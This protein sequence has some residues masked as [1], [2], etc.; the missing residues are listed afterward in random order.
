MLENAIKHA[1]ANESRHLAALQDFIRIPSI[2]T[3]PDH[4]PD[5]Q[6]AASW[7]AE[8]IQS[9]GAPTVE[10]FAEPASHP[11]VYAD[12]PS[13]DPLA[14]TIL[15]YGHYDVQPVDPL[16]EWESEPFTAQQ[17]GEFLYGRGASDMKGQIIAL[18]AALEAA[19]KHAAPAVNFKFLLEGQEEIGSR[20]LNDFIQRHCHQLA[21]DISLNVDAGMLGPS[22]PSITYGLRGLVDFELQLRGP[23][24]DLHSGLFGGIVHNPAQALCEV[25]AGMHTSQGQ[26]L[27]PGFYDTVRPLM[28]EERRELARLPRDDRYYL[29]GSGAPQLWGE[30]EFTALEREGTRPTLEV[31][32]I[33]SG[34]TG[35][36]MKT[37][38]PARAMAKISARLVPDQD[39]LEV[40]NQ[41]EAYLRVNVPP[42][43][44]WQLVRFSANPAVLTDRSSTGVRAMREALEEVWRVRPVFTRGGGSIP[45][46]GL[47]QQELGAESILTGFNLPGDNIHSPNER[48]HLPT[49]R[50]GI[51]ALIRFFFKFGEAGN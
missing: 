29:E 3:N 47:I 26:V 46:V 38:L 19:A 22:M 32:G 44:Q 30:P 15:V 25:I 20:Q 21:C 24:R 39:P 35:E 45:V 9:L 12:W 6:H 42:T 50:K 33:L 11:V 14:P 31:N 13:P 2:S 8:Q 43:M 16:D 5:M 10:I 17:R 34:F 18:F 4:R 40:H 36:G 23:N 7:A 49:W 37:V 51:E 28:E 48:L 41:L 1:R 27:L